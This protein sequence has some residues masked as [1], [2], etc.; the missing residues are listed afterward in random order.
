MSLE[1]ACL[2]EP[3]RGCSNEE[4]LRRWP[5]SF[6]FR[7]PVFLEK[8]DRWNRARRVWSAS[9]WSC[10]VGTPPWFEDEDC[11]DHPDAREFVAARAEYLEELER[12]RSLEEVR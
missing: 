6:R 3:F 2:P 4:L 12:R 1:N 8:W 5:S 7:D 9:W 11:P 10:E